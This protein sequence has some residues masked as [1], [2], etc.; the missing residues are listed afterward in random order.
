MVVRNNMDRFQLAMDA[1]RRVSRVKES[2]DQAIQLFKKKLVEHEEYIRVHG[3]DLPEV[4]GWKWEES[5][6]RA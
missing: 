3:E 5:G 4:S 2:S 6:D 1:I